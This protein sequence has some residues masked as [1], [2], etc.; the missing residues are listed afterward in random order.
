M[1]PSGAQIVPFISPR[2]LKR[3][4]TNYLSKHMDQTH[5][6]MSSTPTPRRIAAPCQENGGKPLDDILTNIFH[7]QNLE[8][9]GEQLNSAI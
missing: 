6:N 1:Q 9:E 3:A 4:E 5:K 2:N 8:V 7:D